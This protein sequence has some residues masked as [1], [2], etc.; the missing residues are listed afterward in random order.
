MWSPSFLLAVIA[1]SQSER[2][3][4]PH[5]KTVRPCFQPSSQPH[6]WLLK[7]QDVCRHV[8]RT[9]RAVF[10]VDWKQ[11]LLTERIR[12]ATAPLLSVIS[13]RKHLRLAV[14]QIVCHTW[15]TWY[16]AYIFVSLP[17]TAQICRVRAQLHVMIVCINIKGRVRD[18]PELL[19][20]S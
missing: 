11:S 10:S 14:G 13:K 2:R 19:D 20:F 5:S 4:P 9:G 16:C 6:L 17:Y 3:F 7:L 8:T 12:A 1:V 18:P 15:H